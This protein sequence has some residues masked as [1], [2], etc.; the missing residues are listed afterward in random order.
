VRIE[1]LLT[2]GEATVDA[3][4]ILDTKRIEKALLRAR[5]LQASELFECFGRDEH[6][7]ALET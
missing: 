1:L 5:P 4:D 2:H 7:G 6:S 3:L